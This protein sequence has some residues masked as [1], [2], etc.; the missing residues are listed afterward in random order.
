[1]SM[2]L[3]RGQR[4]KI[5]ALGLSDGAFSVTVELNT[6]PLTVD[7]ACF[8]LDGSRKLSDE[9]YM[10]FFNQPATPCGAVKLGQQG[11]FEFDLARL[12]ASI[13]VLVMTLAVDGTGVM[14]QLGASSVSIHRGATPSG[15]YRFDGSH[16]AA[17]RAVMLLE[18]YRKDGAWRLCAVGQGFNGGLDALVT[19]F[20]GAVAEKPSAPPAAPSP[21][22]APPLPPSPPKVSLSKVTLE[23]RGEKISLEK[24]GQ[25]G[26]GRIVCNL[27]WSAGQAQEK[28]GLLGGM[29]GKAKTSGIDL[30]LGCLYEMTDGTKWG[31]QALGNAFGDF[32]RPPYIH[33]AGD[34]RTGANAS[35]EFLYIN[36]DHLKDLRRIC[37]FALIY[38]GVANWGQADGVVTITVPGHPPVE[39][40]LDNHDNTRN[41]CAIA[42]IE[43]DGGNLKITKLAEYF[44]GHLEL[45]QRYQWG[46]NYKKGSKD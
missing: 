29:F 3:T 16:F 34:D 14:N 23:K 44:P 36:G 35:G 1:M 37:I 7:V 42:M 46:L 11:R 21:A 30:D 43:N 10:T 22:P 17:E 27:N 4:L 13:Q 45:D 2:D 9:R 39:V 6:G 5:D 31:V 28:R 41:M 38:E 8:G 40:R 25:A 18:F 33:L 12:P 19:H 15:T 26:H 20:G 24:R 32:N